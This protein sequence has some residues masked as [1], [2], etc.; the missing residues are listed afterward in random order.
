Q[1]YCRADR[2]QHEPCT[3]CMS[4]CSS[5]VHLQFYKPLSQFFDLVLF[6]LFAWVRTMHI[7]P[8]G[9]YFEDYPGAFPFLDFATQGNNESL[10]IREYNSASCGNGENDVKYAA[11]FCFHCTYDSTLCY[12]IPI[13]KIVPIFPKS[14]SINDFK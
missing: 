4:L 10:Y 13:S 9:P 2:I 12:R 7:L 11:M 1:K 3:L 14:D 6:R 8:A 5:W